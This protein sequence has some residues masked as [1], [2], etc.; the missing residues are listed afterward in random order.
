M[1]T[2]PQLLAGAF[3]Q[4][5]MTVLIRFFLGLVVAIGVASV[6]VVAVVQKTKEI[7]ILRAMGARRRRIMRVFLLQGG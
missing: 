1:H 7:G 4:T 2:N 5:V 3:N 6:L